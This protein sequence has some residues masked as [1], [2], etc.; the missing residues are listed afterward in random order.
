MIVYVGC[1]TTPDRSGRGEGISAYRMDTDSGAWQA[2]GV[3]ARVANPSYL[4]VPSNRNLLY[5][6]H[7]GEMSEVSGFAIDGADRLIQLGTW[8]SGGLNPVHLD[9][10]RDARWMVVANYTGAT[11]ASLPIEADGKL[12]PLRDVVKID[13]PAGPDSVQQGSPHPHDIPFD[14]TRSFVAV[15]D[16]GLDRVFVFRFDSEHGRYVPASPPYVNAEPG[17]GPRHIAF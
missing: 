11:L 1:Y 15:P 6:V 8:S 10:D 12:G 3:V 14:P 13:G 2:L 4:A 5:C 16:K 7:G 17:A 9:F